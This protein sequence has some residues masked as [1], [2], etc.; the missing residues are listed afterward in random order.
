M[1]LHRD[2]GHIA[3]RWLGSSLV[4]SS[5]PVELPGQYGDQPS[6]YDAPVSPDRGWTSDPEDV[7]TL[8]VLL[9]IAV[10]DGWPVR[11]YGE[12]LRHRWSD[13]STEVQL[14]AKSLHAQKFGF[15][16]SFSDPLSSNYSSVL[17]EPYEPR[18]EYKAQAAEQ[19]RMHDE[20][21]LRKAIDSLEYAGS[22]DLI[23]QR[24]AADGVDF[25]S[26]GD[27]FRRYSEEELRG[28]SRERSQGSPHSTA[29]DARWNQ[30]VVLTEKGHTTADAMRAAYANDAGR[31]N[32]ARDA[33][34][35]YLYK[36]N[37]P[38][39][40]DWFRTGPAGLLHGATLSKKGLP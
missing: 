26:I 8:Q 22:I 15:F 29:D 17:P 3:G 31:R 28:I 25:A 19:L 35:D 30:F 10:K 20:R 38:I 33:L 21:Q 32:V 11:M 16:G 4:R 27:R 14:L 24:T 13:N 18:Q 36:G 1:I 37:R 2:L 34:L 12:S 40:W 23:D 5:A 6:A 39:L 9:W 7:F